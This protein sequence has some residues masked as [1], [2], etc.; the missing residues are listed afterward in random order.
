MANEI[1]V[2]GELKR[3]GVTLSPDAVGRVAFMV[4][5]RWLCTFD[6]MPKQ[7][8]GIYRYPQ[9]W[10][11]VIADEVQEELRRQGRLR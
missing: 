8:Q 4:C 6:R 11:H 10:G 7:V 1:T 9:S 3:A 2:S 5:R